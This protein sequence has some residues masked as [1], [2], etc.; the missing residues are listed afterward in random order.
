M[1]LIGI[2][3]R[4]H[5]RYPLLVAANRDEFHARPADPAGFWLDAPNL[6]AGRDRLGGG[7]WLGLSLAGR[8]AAV[9]NFR[10]PATATTG[11]RSRG[12]LVTRFLAGDE[13]ASGFARSVTETGAQYGG[14]SLLVMDRDSL[15]FASNRA[16][17]PLPVP[18]GVHALSNQ[19]L[20]SPWPKVQRMRE[21]LASEASNTRPGIE[22]LLGS[23]RD[24]AHA[25]DRELPDT[26]VGL[27]RER[28]LSP[29]FIVD[30]E[31]GTRCSTLVRV[32][33]DDRV[34]FREDS[35]GPAGAML[36][37]RRFFFRLYCAEL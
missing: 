21:Q 15:W 6:I 18:P 19:T 28:L 24:T 1:C 26:G 31:Y 25:P 5:P 27:E 13:P 20:D 32:D 22:P 35:Y 4:T 14:F 23:L 7:T 9:T 8:F 33:A 36:Y 16:E 30:K 34:L 17:S 29:P 10:E 12:E 3:Y 2:A 11:E 37:S